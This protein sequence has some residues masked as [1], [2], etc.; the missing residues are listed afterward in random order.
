M[1][2]NAR[3]MEKFFIFIKTSVLGFAA[4]PPKNKNGRVLLCLDFRI[5]S[6]LREDYGDL[7]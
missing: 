5:C 2:K 4:N 7:T 6:E 1:L 3:L